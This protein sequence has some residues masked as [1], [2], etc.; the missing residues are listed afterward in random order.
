MAQ[1][2]HNNPPSPV[3]AF[4]EK[5]ALYKAGCDAFG[6]ITDDNA[7]EVRDHVGYGRDL[8]VEI[9]KHREAEKKPHLDA[10]RKIDGTFKP[11]V[12]ETETI[13]KKLKQRLG[14]FMANRE[15]EARKA[16]AEAA[17]KLREAEEAKAEQAAA[18]D[19]DPFLAATAEIE[20]VDTTQAV[21]DVKAAEAAV[22][23]SSRVSSS[24]GG[25]V[26]AGLKTVRKAKI[27][28]WSALVSHYAAHPDMQA[29]AEKLAN[30][31]IRHAKGIEIAIPG[32]E[33]VTERVL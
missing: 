11:L 33:I 12:D 26:A 7:Q 14:A 20:E 29:L 2:A 31:D 6:D 27:T 10:G 16:A 4:K 25:F 23:A 19:D 30:A 22:L 24:A 9:D 5:I 13:Q 28:N 15:E 18:N 1:A 3:E 17:R 8:A 32:V 21:A